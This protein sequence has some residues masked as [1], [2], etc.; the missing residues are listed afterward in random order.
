[1]A[2]LGSRDYAARTAT[3]LTAA[4]APPRRARASDWASAMRTHTISGGIPVHS[5]GESPYIAGG[6][7]VHSWGKNRRKPL[8]CKDRT[9]RHPAEGVQAA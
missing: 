4:L 2:A 5:W 7:P 9:G 1:M 8:I 3:R 6:I